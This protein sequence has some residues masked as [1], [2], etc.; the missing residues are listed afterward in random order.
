MDI[1]IVKQF[2]DSFPLDKQLTE[3]VEGINKSVT[4][5]LKLT[6]K[7][8]K[9]KRRRY[10]DEKAAK[11]KEKRDEKRREADLAREDKKI[12]K[13]IKKAEKKED[14]LFDKLLKWG[15]VGAGI[16]GIGGLAYIFRDE[17]AGAIGGIVQDI[18]DEIG[19]QLKNIQ[20]DLTEWATN[21][22]AQFG[23]DL[24]S[25]AASPIKAVEERL[26]IQRGGMGTTE[27]GI[28]F[29][30]DDVVHFAREQEA[31]LRDNGITGEGAD[32]QLARYNDL[33]RAMFEHKRLNDELYKKRQALERLRK[34]NGN[35]ERRKEERI[36][37]LEAEISELV[38]DKAYAQGRVTELWGL[39]GITDQKLLERQ[40]VET[41]QRQT[42]GVINSVNDPAPLAHRP[43][44]S[45][46][47]SGGLDVPPIKRQTGGAVKQATKVLMKDEALSSLTKGPNDYIMP[48]GTS[49]VS[50]TPWSAVKDNT[51]V[52]AYKDSV[53]QTTIG[54][55]STYYDNIMNGK[56]PVKMGDTI[57]KKKADGVLEK[58]VSGLAQKY[59]QEM[60]FWE[61]MTQTQKA[62]LLTLGYNAPNAPIGSFPKL[63]N[64][65]QR[66]NMSVAA[67]NIGRGGPNAARI[68][69][70]RRM[71]LSGP[72]DL[73]QVP[74]R[75]AA[76]KVKRTQSQSQPNML[77]QFASWVS[78]PFTRR[79]TG[80]IVG[81][82]GSKMTARLSEANSQHSAAKVMTA[83]PV[84]V[85]KRRSPA[86]V[87]SGS[88][89][90]PQS[91]TTKQGL[92]MVEASQTLHRI[93]SGSKY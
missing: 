53:G 23:K 57:T 1:Q 54:W 42:G 37:K 61:K 84:V 15:A 39:L 71:I 81:G 92:N 48:G 25:F 86:P 38:N 16:A 85:V 70:E 34:A 3:S 30:Y 7:G 32:A 89:A 52:H 79:Q 44:N 28:E 8:L 12:E 14:S 46:R 2:A 56:Q 64:A 21:A 41:N 63:T 17:I 27:S 49:V 43:T 45:Q 6:D 62:G 36:L 93:Q 66:G 26:Q 69:E 11:K 68:A 88:S 58:N 18:K 87:P 55:G 51:P 65:L 91:G 10:N 19:K 50:R 4:S 73:T 67:D 83:R 59:S 74:D 82:K 22:V 24:A 78:Q 76:P 40:G 90:F 80:G 20:E 77:Q 75:A 9:E 47:V 31:F 33:Q 60:K 5:L 72:K 29:G 35:K 13:K